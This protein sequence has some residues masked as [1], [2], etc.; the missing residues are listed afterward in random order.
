MV[1]MFDGNP[2]PLVFCF[3]NPA[4]KE[5]RPSNTSTPNPS[6]PRLLSVLFLYIFVV[7]VIVVF[8][9]VK[10]VREISPPFNCICF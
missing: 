3:L 6:N 4:L 5:Q 9:Q 2:A 10:I 1:S 8:A 7:A